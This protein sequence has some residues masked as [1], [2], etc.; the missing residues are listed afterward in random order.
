[1]QSNDRDTDMAFPDRR[2]T[3]ILLTVFFFVL[4]GAAL[5]A[6]RRVLLLFIL[7]VFFA[8]LM[9]PVVRLLQRHALFFRNLRG[10]AVIEVYL[11]FIVLLIALAYVFAPG[12]SRNTGKLVDRVPATLDGLATGEIAA[13][14][15]KEDGWSQEQEARF[16]TFLL[17]HKSNFQNLQAAVDRVLVNAARIIGWLI[18][19]PILAVFLLRD[20]KRIAD[21]LICMLFP[22]NRRG[23]AQAVMRELHVMLSTYINAQLQLCM[24]S[25]LFYSAALLVLNFSHAMALAFLGGL[26]EF[27]PV[28]GWLTML[29]S[30]VTVGFFGHSHWLAATVLFGM[31]RL[32]QDYVFSPWI[33]GRQLRMHPLAAIFAI[34]VGAEVGGIV[35]VYLAI[36]LMASARVIWQMYPVRESIAGDHRG[37][38]AGKAELLSSPSPHPV[39]YVGAIP[40][41]PKAD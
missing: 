8:Y 23:Q 35:G 20:G 7:A 29:A 4:L 24:L 41:H 37:R 21:A 26:L 33:M 30:V 19:V 15:A 39:T 3:D 2:T 11:L 1:M 16:H 27:V 34:L 25:F 6:A 18:L 22:S 28:A 38:L 32:L 31:W 13:Q 5:Y 10:P 14:L 12:L 40:A 9:E 17:R 36:P